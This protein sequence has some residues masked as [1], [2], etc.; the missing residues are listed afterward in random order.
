M[1]EL[2]KRLFIGIPVSRKILP[3]LRDIQ[4]SIVHIPGQIRWV[5][6]EKFHM[7]LSFLGNVP[8]D[9]IP[10]LIT[11]LENVLD[12]NHF[13]TSIEKT[14]VFPLAQFPKILWLGV[15]NGSQKLGELHEKIKKT[16]VSFMASKKKGRFIP[17]ITIGRAT[18][19]YRKSAV[20]PFLKYVYS[21]IELDVNSVALYS[22]QL[23]PEGAEYKVLTE[24]A[25]N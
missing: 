5:P 18:R 22:S 9:D 11:D 25:L 1:V 23:L 19:S 14:G 4:S 17:H 10:K 2:E 12:Y 3:K 8:F 7:T 16:A 6:P 15:G 24:F 21:P 13:S 20:L